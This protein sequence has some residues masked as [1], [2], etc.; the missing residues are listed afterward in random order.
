MLRNFRA[1]Q[2]VITKF[3]ALLRSD[4]A[5]GEPLISKF[6]GE[7]RGVTRNNVDQPVAILKSTGDIVIAA[8]KPTTTSPK[9]KS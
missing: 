6:L 1:V 3:A 4:R 5:S 8:P 2:F 9:E 7:A